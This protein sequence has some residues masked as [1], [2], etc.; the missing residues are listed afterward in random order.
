MSVDQTLIDFELLLPS[1]LTSETSQ[2]SVN[3]ESGSVLS[4]PRPTSSS[5]ITDPRNDYSDTMVYPQLDQFNGQIDGGVG[6]DNRGSVLNGMKSRNNW[7]SKP[8]FAENIDSNPFLLSLDPEEREKLMD[9]QSPP[10]TPPPMVSTPEFLSSVVLGE[11]F[12]AATNQ[13][14]ERN[15]LAATRE[16]SEESSSTITSEIIDLLNNVSPEMAYN[17]PPNQSYHSRQDNSIEEPAKKTPRL[18]VKSSEGSTLERSSYVPFSSFY[19]PTF[20]EVGLIPASTSPLLF[21]LNLDSPKA[22]SSSN[23]CPVCGNEAGK[24]VH[25]GGKACTSC[26]AFFRRSVQVRHNPQIQLIGYLSFE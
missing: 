24:H 11:S 9:P 25:Y 12:L 4:R 26:R 21:E 19:P 1:N 18:S 10:S 20:E 8:C 13:I 5:V 23:L 15:S 6:G 3:I 16:S 22:S 7:D 2:S 17:L 14:K